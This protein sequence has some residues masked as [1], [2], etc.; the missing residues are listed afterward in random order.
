MHDEATAGRNRCPARA[1]E[2][3]K[4]PRTKPRPRHRR[5]HHARSDT[6]QRVLACCLD[7]RG[8]RA[9]RRGTCGRLI[10]ADPLASKLLTTSRRRAEARARHSVVARRGQLAGDASSCNPSRGLTLHWGGSA[11]R[12]GP[13]ASV[14]CLR[15][16]RC[17]RRLR[18]AC[19]LP[20]VQL[21]TCAFSWTCFALFCRRCHLQRARRLQ[22]FFLRAC[23]L[24]Q[25]L[26]FRF[27][28]LGATQGRSPVAHRELVGRLDLGVH[29]GRVARRGQAGR[30]PL[31]AREGRRGR[32][33]LVGLRGLAQGG[34]DRAR[35]GRTTLVGVRT[36]TRVPVLATLALPLPHKPHAP[37]VAPPPLRLLPRQ[38]ARPCRPA[39]HDFR[40]AV[41]CAAPR[42]KSISLRAPFASPAG[43]SSAAPGSRP[44]GRDFRRGRGR[45]PGP[46]PPPMNET[47]KC[48]RSCR[49]P[50]RLSSR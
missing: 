21:A 18:H 22:R 4:L 20:V 46:P 33:A 1:P 9:V 14:L 11:D 38:S 47:I 15:R 39:A 44:E 42:P 16:W 49:A 32:R 40:R 37:H 23:P 34:R 41:P 8:G 19:R 7:A 35:G 6:L 10:L 31:R 13:S 48:G 43:S 29:R 36:L 12:Q 45:D 3:H 24:T 25:L 17:A 30:R 26:I 50:P 2:A 27:R 5:L 28:Q